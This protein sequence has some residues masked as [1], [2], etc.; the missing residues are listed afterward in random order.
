[1]SGIY[2]H[3]PFCKQ[4]CSYC[5]FH[6]STSFALYRSRMIDALCQELRERSIEEP[7]PLET[8]YVGGGTPSLLDQIEL[9]QL[10]D[11][12]T[13][14]F[15]LSCLSEVTLEANPD[16]I[17][18]DKLTDWK[19]VGINRLS[20]GLQSFKSEDL[21]W[22]NRA[23]SL[24]EALSC[25]AL[26][27][28]HGFHN[29]SVDLMYGLPNLTL[30]EWERHIDMVLSMEVDHISAYCLTIEQKTELQ[31]LVSE[32]KIV[33]SGEDQ[34]SDQFEILS[35]R[36]ISAGYDHYEISNFAKPGRYAIHNSNY[37]KGA[38]Y[39]GVGPSA[40]SYN[41]ST[42][43]WNIANNVIYMNMKGTTWY[44]KEV[45][46][47]KERWNELLLTGLRT[48]YGV[49]QKTLFDILPPDE[50]FHKK[51]REF[52][53]AGLIELKKNHLILTLKG[54]LKADYVTSELFK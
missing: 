16:D 35:N 2:I 6:F 5:D 22:M 13:G 17:N 21:S 49:D 48:S 27:R 12:L 1:M 40:H 28:S 26:A 31:H 42:R 53:Y 33:P 8:I 39:M 50:D 29:I 36:L 45:L 41:G 15:D 9:K 25:V 43:R 30:D 23:H 18:P 46:G 47:T 54:R 24:Q 20:I 34:Q 3:I 52:T 32:G 38:H 7:H 19:R 4:K 37:W 10:F 44:E 11:T 14:Y 51:V